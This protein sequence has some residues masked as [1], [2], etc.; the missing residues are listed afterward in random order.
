M[1]GQPV[2]TLADAEKLIAEFF[3]RD[4]SIEFRDDAGELVG[5][6]TPKP[7]VLPPPDPL[8]PWDPSITRKELDRRASEPGFSIEEA[9]E[10]LGR[11]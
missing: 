8:V 10:R 4:Q 5:T 6:F 3:C 7:P 1:A 11:A 9:R 2:G